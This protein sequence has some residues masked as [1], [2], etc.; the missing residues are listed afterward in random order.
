[1][2][3]NLGLKYGELR[4]GDSLMRG[5]VGGWA[6]P[7]VACTQRLPFTSAWRGRPAAAAAA[8]AAA[9]GL[10]H[11]A[12][13]QAVADHRNAAESHHAARQG[14]AQRHAV[15]GQQRA[16]RHGHAHKVVRHCGGGGGMG[17]GAQPVEARS[18]QRYKPGSH[19]KPPRCTGSAHKP[20]AVHTSPREGCP[21]RAHLPMPGSGGSWP[22]WR[23][24]APAPHPPADG[25]TVLVAGDSWV[26]W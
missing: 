2:L 16:C 22:G 13:A 12:Q 6:G 5:W 25:L 17:E 26:G 18:E 23:A 19:H 4:A 1:M 8:A 11:P 9:A 21:G 24:P 14:G 10:D 7:S 15:C 20:A 3:V